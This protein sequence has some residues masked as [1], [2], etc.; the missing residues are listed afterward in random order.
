MLRTL[1][2]NRVLKTLAA[3]FIGAFSI[4][5]QAADLLTED[6]EGLVLNPVVTFESEL[7]E[8]EAWQTVGPQGPAGWTEVNLTTSVGDTESGVLEFEGWRF[9]DKEWWNN[10]AGDQRRS[11]FFNGIGIIA[12]ADPDE[13]DDFGDPAN[14]GDPDNDSEDDLLPATGVFDSTLI[15]PSIDISALAPSETVKLKFSSSWRDE[16]QQTATL[17]AKYNLGDDEALHRWASDET[18]LDFKDDSTNETLTY[19]L[20][21]I[22]VG[23]TSVQ[24]EFRLQGNNDWWWAIDNLQVFT[25]TAPGTDGVLRVTID[26]VTG[27]TKIVNQTGDTVD[28][29]GYSIRSTDGVFDEANA[30]FQADT[31]SNWIQATTAGGDINDLSEVHVTS[32]PLADTAEINFGNV[33]QQYIEEVEDLQFEYLIAGSDDPIQGIIEFVGNSDLAYELLDLNFDNVIDELDWQTFKAGYGTDLT[34]LTKAVRYSLSDLNDDSLH[35]LEDFTQFQRLYDVAN[36][37][38]A[39]IAMLS[40]TPVPEPSTALT[41]VAAI[42]GFSF[43]RRNRSRVATLAVLF[44]CLGLFSSNSAEAQ[45]ILLQEDFEGVT[46]QPFQEEE[47]GQSGDVWTNV[48]PTGWTTDNSGVPGIGDPTTDGVID[49]ANWAFVNKD[50]WVDAAGGQD[51]ELFDFGTGNV[52]VADADEWDDLDGTLR[53]PI[54]QTPTPDNLY[55]VFATT[56][57]LNIPAGLPAGRIKLSFDSSWRPEAFDD[58]DEE[59][60]QTATLKAIY[61]GGT[62]IEIVNWDSD[63]ESDNFRADAPNERFT[64]I[65]LQYD[66]SATTL[67]LEF[68]LT[69]AWNDWWWAIDNV[70]VEV[71][72]DPAKLRI[73]VLSG[74]ATI[75]GDDVISSSL[76]GIDIKSASGSLENITNGG[77]ANSITESADGPDAGTTAGDGFGEQWELLTSSSSQFAEAFLLGSSSFDDTREELIGQLIDPSMLDSDPAVALANS[78][79][80]FTYSLATGTVVTGVIEYYVG[81]VLPGDFNADGSVDAADYTIWRDNLGAIDE[82]ALNG[83]GNGSGGVD[84]ADY[85]L[86]AQFFGTTIPASSSS[87]VSVPEPSGFAMLILMTSM[88]LLISNRKLAPAGLLMM[89]IALVPQDASA[90]IPSPFVDR[91]YRFGD[92]D[93]SVVIGSN[94]A[95]QDG[96]GDYVTFDDAGQTGQNQLI[97]LIAVSPTS[98]RATYVDTT[99]RPDGNGGVGLQLN[100]LAFDRQYLRTGFGEALNNPE[101]SP[102]SAASQIN[103]GGTLNY[104]RINDRGFEIWVKPTAITGEHHIVMDSQQHGVLI[105]A[106]GNFAMRYGSTFEVETTQE[107]GPDEVLGTPDDVLVVGDPVVTPNDYASDVVAQTN[108]WYHLSVIRPFGPGNGSI[109][110]VNGVA[111]A[112]GFGEYSIE[113]VVNI[114][115]GDVFTNI[116]SLDVSPLTVGR[117]TDEASFDIPLSE[118]YFFRGVVDDLSMFVMGLNDNDNLV[119]GGTNVIND[120]GEYFFERDNGYAQAFAPTVDGDLNNDDLVTL[121]DASIF[122]SNWLSENF[123][124]SVDP[125]NPEVTNTRLVGDL[126][127][128]ALGDFNYDGIVDLGDW[129]I[130]NNQNPGVAAAAM[131]LITAAAVPE[132]NSVCLVAL[133]LLG[134]TGLG[135]RAKS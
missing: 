26:R 97:D 88:I 57:V 35:T 77:F 22:P 23:A 106:N 64:Q 117:A 30:I 62:P 20:Q 69:D 33:W 99:D 90:T 11:E 122:A 135:R 121:A 127:T 84:A 58:L 81:T 9:V 73:D 36:G 68:A 104:F 112:V 115:E 17:T 82:T 114:G 94:I 72:T 130:L 47:D 102:S 66:G 91:D 123:L 128:R 44:V 95:Q 50:A 85:D 119:G 10:T 51:R 89:V 79:L 134:V 111:E 96:S 67:Q 16:D 87:A 61:D 60:N 109:L 59:N 1:C 133:S 78:D 21:S 131:Q 37:S 42:T 125:S 118:S 120:Y 129:A 74:K 101:Q 126:S 83:A 76:T 31:D 6:F 56:P 116:D 52:M 105:D 92:G 103:P 43:I 63:E 25:G 55:D 108:Q 4:S 100:S 41:L 80:E 70:L 40:A 132:P 19:E 14:L 28:L 53:D 38:G 32:D 8:R 98:R 86:W 34:G 45:L 29:R 124:S 46:L 93:N 24:F 5:T 27:E 18:D 75:A 71:P 39:F 3:G 110:Y 54:A 107:P 15:T 13:W 7:R 2:R 48:P 49:W 12:V 65:D 113:T